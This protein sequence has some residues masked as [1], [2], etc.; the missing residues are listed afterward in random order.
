MRGRVKY[1]RIYSGI[2]THLPPHFGDALFNRHP[3]CNFLHKALELGPHSFKCSH[4]VAV[5]FEVPDKT[6]A[7]T[8]H[9]KRAYSS[10]LC[11]FS[12]YQVL[13]TLR[14]RV[15]STRRLAVLT[16]IWMNRAYFLASRE[17]LERQWAGNK[18]QHIYSHLSKVNSVVAILIES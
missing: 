15:Q 6:L 3:M 4:A 5:P 12:M 11:M 13:A 9:M 10:S 18:K 8:L 17:M 16:Y 7:C 14:T 2:K 1:M